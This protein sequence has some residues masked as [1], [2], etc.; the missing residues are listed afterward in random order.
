MQEKDILF[1]GWLFK[2]SRFMRKWR[3]RFAVIT[4][5]HFVTFESENINGTPTEVLVL[6]YCNSVKS[7]E[8]DTNKPN[9]FSIDYSGTLFYFYCDTNEDKTKWIGIVSKRIVLPTIKV[10]KDRDY[11]SSSDED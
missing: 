9:S 7:A 2:Q 5:K 10:I 1:K 4:M 11:D 3:R 6:N 8:E